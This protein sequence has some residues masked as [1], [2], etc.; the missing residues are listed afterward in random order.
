MIVPLEPAAVQRSLT[1]AVTAYIVTGLLFMLLPGTFLG[2][3]NLVSIS[4]LRELESISPAWLQAHGHA[5]I[6]GWI[7]TF[8]LGIGYYSL[9]RMGR[10][11]AFAAR[12]AWTSFVL[13][14]AGVTVH[15]TAGV[16]GWEWR[17]ALPISALLE[18]AGFSFFFATVS[19]HKTEQGPEGPSARQP[20]EPWMLVVISATFGFLFSL[21][22]NLGA[23]SQGA[24]SGNGP[25]LPHSLD[26]RLLAAP[27]WAFLVPTVWGFNARWL[28]VFLGS[29][30]PEA[31]GLLAAVGLAWAGVA[32]TA[33]GWM[34]PAAALFVIAAAGAIVAL[35]IF[36]RPEKPANLA[37]VHPTFPLFVRLAYAWLLI[38]GVLAVWAALA[39]H[40]GGIW[41]ASR[42]AATV[43]FLAAM[44]FAIGQKVLPA[45][46]GARV[47][48]SKRAMFASLLLLNIGC[49]LR[50][51]SEIPA[52]EGFAHAAGFWRVL[53]ISAVTELAAV[54]IFAANLLVTFS[55]LPAHLRASRIPPDWKAA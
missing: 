4:S 11:P 15:W 37:G 40:S 17:I 24:L 53:P 38:G 52:Y 25:A 6:F 28:P 23:V 49:A 1:R 26:Q 34:L 7:G 45:F 55:K 36:A 16:T 42:H 27:V 20:K 8:I 29:R 33:G 2:V 54:A 48:F 13:W 10:L 5:Q 19:G 3:W 47:L 32:C 18:L 51:S 12:R 35:H 9:S 30:P 44:V 46:C 14:T 21:L 43:G 31:R 41:G 22:L 39:D 50:V